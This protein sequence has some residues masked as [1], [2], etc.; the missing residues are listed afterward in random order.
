MGSVKGIPLRWILAALVLTA[1]NYLILVGYHFLAVR[2]PRVP[3]ALW[4]V[5]LASFTGYACSYNIVRHRGGYF[6]PLPPLLG[7]GHAAPE[8]APVAGHPGPHVLVWRV[9]LGGRHF[10]RRSATGPCDRL[11]SAAADLPHQQNDALLKWVVEHPRLLFQYI[12]PI[13]VVLLASA[14]AYLGA[15]AWH[16]GSIK[17]FRWTLPVPPFQLTVCQLLVAT[18]DLLVAAWVLFLLMPKMPGIDYLEFVG[19]YMVAY[20]LVVLSHVPGGLGVLEPVILLLLP[21]PFRLRAFAALL[22]F[23]VIY[24]WVP[25]LIAFVLLAGYELILRRQPPEP[26]GGTDDGP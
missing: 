13:G 15:A 19:I 22:V 20:V 8:S 4:K 1:V 24:F 9:R 14:A 26:A 10:R 2:M 23:R 5:A 7:L 18:A 6:G 17:L 3:L 25:L 16:K 21:C 11:R 12:R